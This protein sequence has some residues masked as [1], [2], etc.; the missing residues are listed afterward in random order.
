MHIPSP[1]T[2]KLKIPAVVSVTCSVSNVE[3]CVVIF[4][5]VASY[6]ILPVVVHFFLLEANGSEVANQ[7]MSV[8][9]LRNGIAC[10]NY[11]KIVVNV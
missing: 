6:P 8:S 4:L 9:W 1:P 2:A 7:M 3:T 10:F 11:Y 5:K